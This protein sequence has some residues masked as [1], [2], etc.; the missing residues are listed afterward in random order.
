MQHSPAGRIYT[1]QAA[2]AR[3]FPFQF[4]SRHKSA[5]T[6]DMRSIGPCRPAGSFFSPFVR[7]RCSFNRRHVVP[8]RFFP[9][10]NT[11]AFRSQHPAVVI[12]VQNSVTLYSCF[13][14]TRVTTKNSYKMISKCHN[15]NVKSNI[16]ADLCNG[17]SHERETLSFLYGLLQEAI[18]SYQRL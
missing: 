7:G 16:C 15:K 18:Q 8:T 10:Q 1:I 6:A 13:T 2:T 14:H 17:S 4:S 5:T 9:F 3:C 12:D 11:F